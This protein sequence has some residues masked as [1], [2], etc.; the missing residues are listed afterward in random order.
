MVR[1]ALVSTP[2]VAVPPLGYGGTELVVHELS[3]GLRR[4]GHELV[5][6]ATGDSIGPEVRYLFRKP[7]WPPQ[8]EAELLHCRASARDIAR[9]GFD[10]A[11]AHLAAMVPLASSLGVPL[12]YTIHHDHDQRLAEV[13][14]QNRL[15]HYVAVSARQAEL[16]PGIACDVVPHGLDPTRYPL[17]QGA[18]DYAVFLGRLSWC[19]GPDLAVAAARR[20]GVPIRIAGEVHAMDATPEW[21]RLVARALVQRGVGYVGEVGGEAKLRFLRDARALLMPIRWEEPFGLVMVEAMLCGTPVVAFRRGAAPEVVDEGVTGSLVD[22]VE[23]MAAALVSLA[24]FDREACRK[25][26][27]ARF[28]TGRMARDYERIY[29]RALFHRDASPTREESRYAR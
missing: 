20:A 25:R 14:R 23:E 7:V 6:F 26:A 13:Y 19:K 17:G 27:V 4:L 15:V 10:L 22:G 9:G 1:I 8:P 28:S 16:H 3:R 11:H 12:V 2:F 24:A 18:G 29:A 21:Q 5:L